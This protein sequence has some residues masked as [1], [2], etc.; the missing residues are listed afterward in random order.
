MR[1]VRI[2][3]CELSSSTI[4]D[5]KET[6]LSSL[7]KSDSSSNEIAFRNESIIVW[8]S[9]VITLIRQS[10]DRITFI[11]ILDHFVVL[12]CVL[13]LI[14]R[15]GH[16]YFVVL[17]FQSHLNCFDFWTCLIIWHYN[18]VSLKELL[19]LIREV[20]MNFWIWSVLA[21][22]KYNDIWIWRSNFFQKNVNIYALH[23]RSLLTHQ[24]F[25]KSW[26][27]NRLSTRHRFHWD[28]FL[29]N[30]FHRHYRYLLMSL[31]V[32]IFPTQLKDLS[33]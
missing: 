7:S 5:S 21:D 6:Y 28:S 12:L 3:E 8:W 19:H 1:L 32:I 30:F 26:C 15:A 10:L 16:D 31:T 25:W 17:I 22:K 9:D 20:S 14:S 4:D 33:S 2:E 27:W 18:K 13:Q 24:E 11:T 29:Q 23:S